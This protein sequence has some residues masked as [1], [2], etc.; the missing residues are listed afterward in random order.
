VN[1][2]D[3]FLGF[4][5][6]DWY[7]KNGCEANKSFMKENKSLINQIG[8]EQVTA[9]SDVMPRYLACVTGSDPKAIA[10]GFEDE[11]MSQFAEPARTLRA[12]SAPVSA[13]VSGRVC[14]PTYGF[15]IFF[16]STTRSIS[17]SDK[18]QIQGRQ[19]EPGSPAHAR[20]AIR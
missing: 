20:A 16:G 1:S 14:Y 7:A 10:R 17:A 13:G 9:C 19:N 8:C 5:R 11:V 2:K 12:G 15:T 6:V 3:G 4:I 18:A